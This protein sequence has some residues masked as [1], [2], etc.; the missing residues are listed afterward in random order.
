[1]KNDCDL[2]SNLILEEGEK[3]EFEKYIKLKGTFLHKWIY[4]IIE[5]TD[6]TVTY[7]EL[8]RIIK[9]D[10]YIRNVLYKYLSA[11]EELY[12]SKVFDKLE[13]DDSLE[14]IRNGKID[15]IKVITKQEYSNSNFYLASFNK[16]FTFGKLIEIVKN[17]KSLLNISIRELDFS[18]VINL[19]NKVMHHNLLLISY[20]KNPQEIKQNIEEVEKSVEILWQALDINFRD[21]LTYEINNGNFKGGDSTKDANLRRF[22]L[23]VFNNGVFNKKTD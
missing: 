14:R 22:C 1:M 15:I 13:Y 16:N 6:G 11:L 12:R 18:K 17:F 7:K 8:S 20:Y 4:D 19:R 10:K 2:F 3:M 5:S 21:A 23:G 9:Y